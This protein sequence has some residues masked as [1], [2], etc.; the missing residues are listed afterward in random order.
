MERA[1]GGSP[2]TLDLDWEIFLATR[3][4]AA[5]ERLFRAYR[6]LLTGSAER[7]V[8]GAPPSVEVADLMGA[9]ACGL[10]QAIDR[11]DPGNGAAFVT[12]ALWY[13]RGSML[14]VLRAEDW[15]PRG[16]RK[17]I[18]RWQEARTAVREAGAD[19]SA[20]EIAASAGEPVDWAHANEREAQLAT[21]VSLDDRM[22]IAGWQPSG[23]LPPRHKEV[24]P[25]EAPGPER[26]ALRAEERRLLAEAVL[27]LSEREQLAVTLHYRG[28]RT[29]REIGETLGV[30]EARAFQIHGQAIRKLRNALS[31]DSDLFLLP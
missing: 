10:L 20:E 23:A 22:K 9:G 18:R 3:D 6:Y 27:A 14:E 19:A 31:D 21:L 26:T 29:F 13:V 30:S 2:S 5:R 8:L 28:E 4:E 11:F 17:K 15:A 12:F 1:K 16:V 25:D 24:V 7:I